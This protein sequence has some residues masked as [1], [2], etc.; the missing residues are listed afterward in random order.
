MFILTDFGIYFSACFLLLSAAI[1]V[2]RVLRNFDKHVANSVILSAIICS[3]IPSSGYLIVISALV[4][5]F[6]FTG[7][8][9][10]KL[11]QAKLEAKRIA[12]VSLI[13]FFLFALSNQLFNGYSKYSVHRNGVGDS[14][15]G[16]VCRIR[17]TP[18]RLRSTDAILAVVIDEAITGDFTRMV[19]S[20]L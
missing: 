19:Y 10:G 12:I 16:L 15:S 18:L 11:Y 2:G 1:F 17:P 14:G 7:A 3:M 5:L 6:L 4:S 13:F 20:H 8:V 9:W